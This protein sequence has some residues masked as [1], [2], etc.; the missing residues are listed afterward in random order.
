MQS[1]S[2]L[3]VIALLKLSPELTLSSLSLTSTLTLLLVLSPSLYHT[4]TTDCMG[5]W[6][7]TLNV[8]ICLPN[9]IQ[10]G[11]TRM[12]VRRQ[13]FQPS[14]NWCVRSLSLSPPPPSPPP[15]LTRPLSAC[16]FVCLSESLSPLP[17][18]SL[19]GSPLW[20]QSGRLGGRSPGSLM[21][22]YHEPVTT[23]WVL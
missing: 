10:E 2:T 16:L 17:R 15:S 19:C 5:H 9:Y 7:A 13:A 6:H 1:L 21:E 3:S 14:S 4:D 11:P 12:L 22:S 23:V 8:S 20:P 18:F